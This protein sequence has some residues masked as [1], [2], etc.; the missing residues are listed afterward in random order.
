MMSFIKKCMAAIFAMAAIL[1][2]TAAV[3]AFAADG[4]VHLVMG[5]GRNTAIRQTLN[6]VKTE[7]INTDT[8][9]Y[10][11]FRVPITKAVT[12]DTVITYVPFRYVLESI[13]MEL[14]T[15]N[16]G[17]ITITNENNTKFPIWVKDS[18]TTA[19]ALYLTKIEYVDDIFICYDEASVVTRIPVEKSF[20]YM[21]KTYIPVRE[22]EKFGMIIMW[23]DTYK[24]IHIFRGTDN[25]FNEKFQ[26]IFVEEAVSVKNE[27]IAT[28]MRGIY[29][30]KLYEDEYANYIYDGTNNNN[31]LNN[32]LVLKTSAAT[33]FSNLSGNTQSVGAAKVTSDKSRNLC[34]TAVGNRKY[35]YFVNPD[36][37]RIYKSENT[38]GRV[39][40]GVEV[41]MPEELAG[42]RFTQLAIVSNRLFFVAYDDPS[43][44]GYAYMSQAGSEASATVRLTRS[45]VWN[46]YVSPDNKVYYVN[47]EN[48]CFL[49]SIDIK[50]ADVLNRLAQNV[51]MGTY[52]KIEVRDGVQSMAFSKVNLNTLYYSSI[53]SREVFKVQ[54]MSQGDP[55]REKVLDAPDLETLI[56]FM[57]I[58]EENGAE[59]LYFIM[60][61]K[62]TIQPLSSCK[63]C[64]CDV[65]AKNL[66]T[67]YESPKPM[68]ELSLTDSA[69]YTTDINYSGLYKMNLTLDEDNE[70]GLQ[71]L[72]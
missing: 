58:Y 13:G 17:A 48:N 20:N 14:T 68:I 59:R 45:R 10:N 65:Y 42:K 7:L 2:L 61:D 27:K 50:D 16:N 47:L 41:E 21:D 1:S 25:D 26:S 57:N 44:G 22:L 63:I 28:Y 24:L 11:M 15:G 29:T 18:A 19:K 55:K 60:Y 56:N 49:E 64:S 39:Q 37:G 9:V 30:N 8:A 72:K 33:Y 53:S 51:F 54:L 12:K 66:V 38:G 32:S 69:L 4:Y 3:H 31:S 46:M 70:I 67:L 62:G 35:I 40:K 6:S 5:L 36:N 43:Q 52:G 71:Y 23:D 34:Q